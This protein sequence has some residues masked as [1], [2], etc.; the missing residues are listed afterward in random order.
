MDEK[1]LRRLRRE[2]GGAIRAARQQRT[3]SMTIQELAERAGLSADYLGKVEGG[4]HMLTV[5]NF[6]EICGGLGVSPG[7]LLEGILDDKDRRSRH[8]VRQL[9]A[10]ASQYEPE[11]IAYAREVV[12]VVL[13]RN[14][15]LRR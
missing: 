3:P 9:A 10:L 5:A 12:Q 7:E 13:E 14:P 2:L 15:R 4:R 8:E 6:L 1:H 11:E